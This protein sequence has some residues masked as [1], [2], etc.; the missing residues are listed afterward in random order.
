MSL[1]RE[2]GAR[3]RG[4]LLAVGI[5]ALVVGLVA[6]FAAGRAS[7]PDPELGE[8]V[9]E[10]RASAQPALSA[11]ELVS[12]EYPEAVTGGEVV[13]ETEYG[14]VQSQLDVARSTFEGVAGELELLDPAAVEK[15]RARL[16]G[17]EDAVAAVAAPGVVDRAAVAASASIEAATGAAG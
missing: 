17:L 4:A 9:D 12:I 2:A 5:A 15:A 3:R 10:V 8:L 13:A 1:Y 16:G 6:G 11:L 14:A 7:A